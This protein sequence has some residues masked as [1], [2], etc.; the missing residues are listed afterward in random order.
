MMRFTKAVLEANDEVCAG[1]TPYYDQF[2]V[3]E[4]H[5]YK[6]T[7][8]NRDSVRAVVVSLFNRAAWFLRRIES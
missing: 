6:R 8:V 3:V 1:P 2:W 7:G 4:L 5:F